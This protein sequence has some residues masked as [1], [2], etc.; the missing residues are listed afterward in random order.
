MNL[1]N[2]SIIRVP[3]PV[4][5]PQFD[6][7]VN[8]NAR[9]QLK[10]ALAEL[11][12]KTVEI[13][14][15][16]G[17]RAVKTGT[18]GKVV[19]PHRH[20]HKLADYH[21]AGDKEVQ[22]AIE[23]A[24]DAKTR[25][26]SL[27]W[28]ERA[29]IFLKAAD[30]IAGKY[31][32]QINAASMLST[33]K[34]AYQ[35][36]I[37]AACELIDFLRFNVYY[38]QTIYAE[39]PLRSSRG[40]WN[41][42]Q[43]RPLEGFVLALTPFN[44]TAI[45]GNLATSP[46]IMGNTV[47][48]KPA[49]TSVYT[50]W[51]LMQI[52]KEAGLPDGVI[53]FVPGPGSRVGDACLASRHLGGVHFTGSTAVF[54]HI[55][56]TIGNNIATYRSYPRIVG[57]TGGKDFIFAHASADVDKLVTAC[58]RGA[59]EFQGQKCSAASRAYI[60]ASLWPIVRA[61]LEAEM[62]R[63]KMGPVTDFSNF[64]NAVIDK[65][66]FNTIRTYITDAQAANDAEVIIGGRCDDSQGYFIEPTVILTTNPQFKTM[67]EE[68]FGPVLSV[69][70]YPDE[71]YG[72]TLKTCDR[73]SIYAL[74]GAIFANDRLAISQALATLENAA[75]NFYINDKPT[76]AVVGQQPFG[77][78]RAS[79]TNDKAGAASNLMRWVST[80]AIKETFDAPQRFDYP[81]MQAE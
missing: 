55:W 48:L 72:E 42:T 35:A 26:Q 73:T 37:D 29:A 65:T 69:Y 61:R 67:Q 17:G 9:D 45:A 41:F 10:A 32:F 30:L 78:A 58:I 25:W 66:A 20:A 53:N 19:M 31:R 44:F 43:Y 68:I 52:L 59:F 64:V 36:E 80:R 38:A 12:G 23:A 57:E 76:G 81:F 28:E 40:T 34:N 50:P 1:L 75:G 2:N 51:L 63:I 56:K 21:M 15:I 16:I 33:S 13:P 18:C 3:E 5:E 47:I 14:L 60:P 7:A 8:T 46:A 4:N 11:A 49:S 22:L 77:G 27:R 71:A 62:A 39:Q 74:T 6:Y 54:Q 79:G 24:M 70:V